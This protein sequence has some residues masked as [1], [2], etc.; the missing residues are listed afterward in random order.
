M[1]AGVHRSMIWCA[2]GAPA[3]KERFM[4]E[5]E[6]ER[7][8]AKLYIKDL[9]KIRERTA[10]TEESIAG[11][12]HFLLEYHDRMSTSKMSRPRRIL[13]RIIKEIPETKAVREIPIV[14]L[15]KRYRTGGG[16]E[17]RCQRSGPRSSLPYQLF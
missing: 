1:K 14:S 10:E 5:S 17:N 7:R 4:A 13:M 9:E 12:V 16:G 6:F 11:Y 2:A 3:G 15:K 8:T